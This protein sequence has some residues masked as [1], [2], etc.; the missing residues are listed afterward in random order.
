MIPFAEFQT[1]IIRNADHWNTGYLT[2][3]LD[4][5][6]RKVSKPLQRIKF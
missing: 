1:F 2:A 6:K 4:V 3:I 5:T